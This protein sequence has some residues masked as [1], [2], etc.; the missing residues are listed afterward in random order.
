M[1]PGDIGVVRDCLEMLHIHVLYQPHAGA[2]H[3]PA[4]MHG[5]VLPCF[6]KCVEFQF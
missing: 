1:L 4:S 5:A 6:P 2:L 3:K